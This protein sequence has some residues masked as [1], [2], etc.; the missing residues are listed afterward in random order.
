[1][2]VWAETKVPLEKG[3]GAFERALGKN[4]SWEKKECID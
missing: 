4:P 2:V 1:M 3:E